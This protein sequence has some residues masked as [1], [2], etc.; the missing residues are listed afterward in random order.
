MHSSEKILCASP[1][2]TSTNEDTAKDMYYYVHPYTTSMF[3]FVNHYNTINT[4]FIKHYPIIQT[5][6]FLFA[7]PSVHIN[8]HTAKDMHYYVHP[9]TTSL[10]A[11]LN[12]YNTINTKFT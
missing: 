12:H 8:S 3:A 2:T 7:A 10:F 4:K 5:L 11:F 6:F 9:Y 1:R